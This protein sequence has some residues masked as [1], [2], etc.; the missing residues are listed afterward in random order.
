MK[1][2]SNRA[3]ATAS[4]AS[5]ARRVARSCSDGAGIRP[6][7]EQLGLE[8]PLLARTFIDAR[9][10]GLLSDTP[11]KPRGPQGKLSSAIGSKVCESVYQSTNPD[12]I[13]GV[14]QRGIRLKSLP[15]QT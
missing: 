6:V 8:V 12:P 4:A 13:A 2:S 11:W 7:R 14:Y 15:E 10:V 5:I 1:V 3:L 9:N